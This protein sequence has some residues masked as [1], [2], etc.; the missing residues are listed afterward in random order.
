MAVEFLFH[1][2]K[3]PSVSRQPPFFSRHG[4]GQS[5]QDQAPPVS[6]S[7]KRSTNQGWE[8]EGPLASE[9]AESVEVVMTLD[10]LDLCFFFVSAATLAFSFL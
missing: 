1:G 5:R 10:F 9:T 6:G 4:T 7:L 3:S 2:L 8:L